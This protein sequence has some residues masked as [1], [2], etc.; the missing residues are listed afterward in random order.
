MKANQWRVKTFYAVR[1]IILIIGKYVIKSTKMPKKTGVLQ[2]KACMIYT[3][4]KQIL[5]L[6]LGLDLHNFSSIL[7]MKSSLMN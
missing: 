7:F 2:T 3:A 5:G 6:A 4:W 1:E